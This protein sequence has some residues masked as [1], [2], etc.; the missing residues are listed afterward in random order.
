M[1]QVATVGKSETHDSVLRVDERSES[2]KVGGGTRVRLDVDTP[3]LGVQV[4]SLESSVSAEVLE[5]VNVLVTTVVSGTGETFR[6]FVGQHRSV[7]LH[8]GERGQVL[9]S[10]QLETGELS[11]CLIFNDLGDLGVSLGQRLVEAGVEVL[12]NRDGGG[13]EGSHCAF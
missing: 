3:N 5:D 4:E 13:R 7:G 12:G 1:G 9:R 11:P 6:V 8:D 10:D 2:G